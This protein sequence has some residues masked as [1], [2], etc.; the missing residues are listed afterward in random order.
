MGDTLNQPDWLKNNLEYFGWPMSSAD[1][2]IC[3]NDRLMEKKEESK[4]VKSFYF[5]FFKI[6]LLVLITMIYCYYYLYLIS[7]L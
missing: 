3:I 5:M 7:T 6:Y 1:E 2:F 4:A